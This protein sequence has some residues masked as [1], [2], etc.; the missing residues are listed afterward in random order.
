MQFLCAVSITNDHADIFDGPL[1]EF[2]RLI[3]YY[4]GKYDLNPYDVAALIMIESGGNPDAVN[5]ESGATGLGQIMPRGSG[6]WAENRPTSEELKDPETNIDWTCKILA[7]Y[8]ANSDS[9][10]EAIFSYTGGDYWVLLHGEEV[11]AEMF[12]EKVWSKFKKL[13]GIE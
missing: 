5:T 1:A 11:G 8:I 10:K 4:A 3:F 12:E 2:E 6:N 9:V 13:R 7:F